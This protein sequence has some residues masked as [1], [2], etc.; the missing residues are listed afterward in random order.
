MMFDKPLLTLPPPYAQ[1]R[2]EDGDVVAEAIRRAPEDGAGTL[3][4]RHRPGL[5]AF[6][7]VLEPEQKH[8]EARLAFL[9]G[10]VALAEAL[11]ANCP[12][13]RA[14]RFGWPDTVLYDRA[15]LG[16]GRFVIPEGCAEDETPQWMVFAAELIADR[17]HLDAPGDFPD[18]TS[19]KEEEFTGPQAIMESFAA[20]LMLNFDRWAHQ[21][22]QA[23]TSRY[24]ERLDPPLAEGSRGIGPDCELVERSASGSERR[25]GLMEG[26][27]S[28][29]WRDAAT[30]GPRL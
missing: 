16:G 5:L 15:R 29:S 18:S 4:W 17:D 26:L 6:A 24:I 27:S 21:G 10:M 20:Y 11:V 30:G 3:V 14:V 19:L 25:S 23:V 1:H 22:R 12:P 13:E 7:V 9:G 8:S 28:S 2:L